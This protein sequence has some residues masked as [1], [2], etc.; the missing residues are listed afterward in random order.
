M[1]RASPQRAACCLVL[2]AAACSG[3]ESKTSSRDSDHLAVSGPGRMLADTGFRPGKDGYKFENQG[4]AYPRTPPVLTSQDVARMFG[5]EACIKGSDPNCK[6]KPV[7]TEWMGLVNR[8]MNAGQCEGMAVSSLAFY[9][10]VYS[11]SS[12]A[13]SAKSAHDL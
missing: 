12:F 3:C 4:G 2:L 7:A 8:A 6:L 11:P 13:P 10:K 5:A 1:F 9:K